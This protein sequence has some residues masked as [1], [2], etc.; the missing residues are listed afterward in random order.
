MVFQLRNV[1]ASAARGNWCRSL[2]QNYR[3]NIFIANHS[4][5]EHQFSTVV[6]F[7]CSSYFHFLF[8][9]HANNAQAYIHTHAHAHE[10][11]LTHTHIQRWMHRSWIL[12]D[13]STNT[14]HY[15]MYSIIRCSSFFMKPKLLL[16]VSLKIV[17]T[18]V[19]VLY[20]HF[21][22]KD[23]ISLRRIWSI[24]VLFILQNLLD[25]ISLCM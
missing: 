15:L 5:T 12:K 17:Y 3:T 22:Y 7:I 1:N 9:T 19:L 18:V 20:Y 16:N 2:S 11:T 21:I 23:Y 14:S 24:F 6:S 13:S 10:H 8:S 25:V 4:H